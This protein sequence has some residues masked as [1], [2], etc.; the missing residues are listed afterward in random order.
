MQP[1]AEP[2][3]G[4]RFFVAWRRRC[5]PDM[6]DV[7]R[8]GLPGLVGAAALGFALALFSYAGREQERALRMSAEQSL[9]DAMTKVVDLGRQLEE[10]G[11]AKAVLAE[12][13]QAREAELAKVQ[14]ELSDLTSRSSEAVAT[15][16]EKERVIEDLNRR[17]VGFERELTRL[18]GGGA[19][20]TAP[21]G[22]QTAADSVELETIVVKSQA[23]LGGKVLVVNKEFAFVVVDLGRL[24]SL[25]AGTILSVFRGGSLVGRVQVDEVYESIASAV[26]LPEWRWAEIRQDDLVEEL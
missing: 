12:Q 7:K 13:I 25:R 6:M 20:V 21:D 1:E 16:E 26:I 18:R 4:L 17:L 9:A 15:L 19:G 24:D 2:G 14:Q 3:G 22:A 5:G 23:R 8:W 10:L 11:A